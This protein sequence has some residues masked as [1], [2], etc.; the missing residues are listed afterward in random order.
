M[1]T[2][3]QS[4]RK[5]LRLMLL[6][7]AGML[8]AS[9]ASAQSAGPGAPPSTATGT[10]SGATTVSN[11]PTSEAQT[12]GGAGASTGPASGVE[13]IVVT[14]QRRNER[15]QD[16]PIAITAVTA[17]TAARQGI[18]GTDGLGIAVP[19]LQFS[20]Q[21]AN[22][23][24]P[25]LR[26]V[27]SPSATAG[28]EAPVAV[29]IDDVYIGAPAATLFQFNNI[30]STEVLKGPQGTLFG[31]NA[32]G[33]VV[34]VHTRKPSQETSLD[35][36]TGYGSY[37]TFYGSGYLNAPIT[38]NMAFNVAV[39]GKNQADG[40]GRSV[41]RGD[42]IYK[43]SSWGVRG[44]LSWDP[45]ADTSVLISADHFWT[46][47]DIGQ[48]VV[49]APG[50]VA[51]GGGTFAGPYSSLSDPMDFGRTN[52]WG[53]S[54]RLEHKFGD[55]TFR[56]ITA[57][58]RSQ[59]EF[60]LDSDGSLPGKPAIISTHVYDAFVN[61]LSQ[62][63]Q[64]LSPQSGAFKWIIGSFYYHSFAGYDPVTTSGA[65]YATQGGSSSV[66]SWQKL[67]SYAGFGEASYEFLP[68]TKLTA[69][70]RYTSDSYHDDV[71][72]SNGLSP[73]L[74]PSPF[75]QRDTFSKLTYRA[76]LDTK[77][78]PDILAYASY[79]RGFK[80]G[81]YNLSTPTQV[82]GGVTVPAAVVKP[83]VLDAYEVGLKSDLFDRKVRFN[84]ALYHYNYDNLQI[85]QVSNG[86]VQTIN[87][88]AAR[89][90]G[91]DIDYSFVPSR[92]F[93]LGG[94]VS[95]LDSKFTSF[96]NGPLYVPSP[97]TCTPTPAT[98]GALTGGNSVC[99]VNLAGNQTT[100]APKL[101]FTAS[102]TYTLPTRSGDFSLNGTFYHNSG[103]F[104]EP[105]N[106]LR[107]PRYNLVN[108]ALSW[109]SPSRKY[110][111]KIYGKNLLNEYYLAYA[112]ESTT[113]DSYSPEMPRNFGG[114][115]T[116]HF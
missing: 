87:A 108:G 2:A 88:A 80:S 77:I 102:A 50:T 99:S 47:G 29:Y 12:V 115:V 1:L 33:G 4:N 67:D 34:N 6:S 32:T 63:V 3:V 62:E 31:R 45:D 26:G 54:G 107:Q 40:Y 38:S 41:A 35:A 39:A 97:A 27:G 14:A 92:R 23:G 7:G 103:F 44:Q 70:L 52:T 69:G 55:Y 9:A 96:P 100:H 83:E 109:I 25:F 113:R 90:N 98:T 60:L 105:D 20:R 94:G 114:E 76:I 21:T 79:S 85:G 57:Y 18:T 37:N 51:T 68:S 64:L 116:V 24:A 17:A 43:S 10:T 101:T 42:D 112:S 66:D 81:G 59:L 106:R 56:S 110:E 73:V 111:V 5:M 11:P 93:N 36:T 16:V 104:W 86:K 72:L 65:A 15:I 58:R 71:V 82:V 30:E 53:V 48:D 95:V 19:T 74:P 8:I 13:E 61:S 49:L 22:G 84:I 75:Q 91:I 28:Q 89:M 46:R 78:T